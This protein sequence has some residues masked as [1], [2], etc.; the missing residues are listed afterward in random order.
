MLNQSILKNQS[1]VSPLA[2]ASLLSPKGKKRGR[3]IA[4]TLVLTS[5]V[6][7]FCMLTI[8]LMFNVSP[9][10]QAA[11]LKSMNLPI[12]SHSDLFTSGI[13]VRVENGRYY[14]NDQEVGKDQ[15]TAALAPFKRD[16]TAPLDPDRQIV[17]Q[18]D[19]N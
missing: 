11:N 10:G 9:S 4:M 17:I 13:L 5:L 7:A 18:A 14:L 2:S 12:A 15:L 16:P 1:M 8:Y 3:S 6:D 19:R